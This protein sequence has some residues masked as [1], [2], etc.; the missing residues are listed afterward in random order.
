M[1]DESQ[2][3][4]EAAQPVVT[5]L[6]DCGRSDHCN[7]LAEVMSGPETAE[8]INR[9]DLLYPMRC[10]R[11]D[12]LVLRV[13]AD[14]RVNWMQYGVGDLFYWLMED[15]RTLSTAV[16]TINLW[17]A[18]QAGMIDVQPVLIEDTPYGDDR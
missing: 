18:L 16:E 4:R 7:R 8:S 13:E 15:E 2:T 3:V 1:I 9:E 14:A 12:G 11:D 5:M 10:H 6:Q 17:E